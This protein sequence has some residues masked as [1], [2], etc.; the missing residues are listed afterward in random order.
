MTLSEITNVAIVGAGTQGSRIAF[1][2]A[3]GGKYVRLYDASPGAL[4]QASALHQVLLKERTDDGRLTAE[5]AEAVWARLQ[6]CA[7]LAECVAGAGLVIEAVP[8]KLE[9]KQQVFADMDRLAAPHVLFATNSSSIPSSRIASVTTRPDRIF[10]I[11]FSDPSTDGDLLVEMMGSAETSPSTMETAER[12][13]RSIGLVPV[14]TKREIMGFSFN[15]IWRAIKREAL[16]L[17]DD[18][19]SD[20]EEIDRAWMLEFR[21]P[22]G[23]FGFMDWIGLDV[24]RDIEIRYYLESG[25]EGDRPPKILDD[26]IAQGRLG[27][28]TGRGFYTYPSP[29]Y[30]NESWLRKEDA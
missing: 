25:D 3:L 18:G 23:P 27:M 19:F 15:R 24:V 26:L 30:R 1:R 16:H 11:N 10:N 2:C 22:F 17:V 21:T 8:E 28:K 12:F 9:L 4:A 7:T 13:V 29:A 5:Q 20:Y 14:V 6:P